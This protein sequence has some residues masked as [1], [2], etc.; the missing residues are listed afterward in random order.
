MYLNSLAL[1][2]VDLSIATLMSL[3]MGRYRYVVL[4]TRYVA[5][6]V[7]SQTRGE[8]MKRLAYSSMSSMALSGLPRSITMLMP[9]MIRLTMVSNS[10]ILAMGLY[11]WAFRS[12]TA[13]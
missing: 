5:T 10:A 7:M 1:H 9:A 4:R 6:A 11:L 13:D 2:P 12:L 3:R 8:Y